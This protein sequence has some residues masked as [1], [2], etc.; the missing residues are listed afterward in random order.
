MAWF[1][2]DDGMHRSRKVLAIPRRHRLAAVGLFTIAGSWCSDEETDGVFPDFMLEEWGATPALVTALL[3][4]GLWANVPDSLDERSTNERR[5]L[6]ERGKGKRFA[7]WAEYQPTR[8]ELT[9]KR[10]K[11]AE[12][13]RKWRARNQV[14]EE[15]VTEEG[16]VTNQVSNDSV[17][18]PPTRPVPTRPN[19]SPNGEGRTAPTPPKRGTRI[20]DDFTVTEDMRAWAAERAPLVDVARSTEKFINH[21]TAATG[22]KATKRDW[23][24]TWQNWLLSDQERAEDAATRRTSGYQN[25]AQRMAEMETTARQQTAAMFTTHPAA[26]IEGGTP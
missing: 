12:K 15:F 21:W 19:Y 4:V 20:P 13:L 7:K 11:N 23:T 2:I 16:A 14:T 6:N 26:A 10:N 9:E 25:T 17:T 24:R 5:V 22:A 1:K 8:D 3:N 18:L